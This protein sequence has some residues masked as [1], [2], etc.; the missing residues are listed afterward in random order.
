VVTKLN[1]QEH[2]YEGARKSL[3]ASLE[4]LKMDYVDL[5]LI[6]TPSRGNNM[7]SWRAMCEMKNEG[8]VKSI[9]VSNFNIQH[10]K[11]MLKECKEN[12]LHFPS[13]N[14]FEIHPWLQIKEAIDYCRENDI[15]VMGYSP[16]ARNL[17]FDEG[18]APVIDQLSAR[19]SKTKAQIVLRWAIQK[20]FITIPKSSNPGRIRENI[21]IYDFSLTE[22]EVHQIDCLNENKRVTSVDAMHSEWLG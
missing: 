19:Y 17:N 1:F 16:V 21:S 11:P 3:M 18:K 14:Q 13:V 2:G 12:N 20:E 15:A 10:L 4:N 7:S 5:L 8:L 9:G 6:H 22:N